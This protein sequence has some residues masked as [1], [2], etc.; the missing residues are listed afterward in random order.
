MS[1]TTWSTLSRIR[2]SRFSRVVMIVTL[3]PHSG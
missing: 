2:E 3:P 1:A